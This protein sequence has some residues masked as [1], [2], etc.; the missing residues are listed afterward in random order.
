MKIYAEAL[1]PIK[2]FSMFYKFWTMECRTSEEKY[3]LKIA[4]DVK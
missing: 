4:K 1:K 2:I 3:A